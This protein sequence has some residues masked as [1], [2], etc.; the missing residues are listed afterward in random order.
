MCIRVI[1]LSAL[2]DSAFHSSPCLL[3][4]VTVS[5]HDVR[6]QDD[7][8][9]VA[10][11]GCFTCF[12]PYFYFGL[13]SF[14]PFGLFWLGFFFQY[15]KLN[16]KPYISYAGGSQPVGN[17]LFTGVARGYQNAQIFTLCSHSSS[18]TTVMKKQ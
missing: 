6:A 18:T 9:C 17:D 16:P 3:V 8:A 15:K 1:F 12:S 7:I 5:I 13:Y 4:A 2:S 10:A 14:L 11:G